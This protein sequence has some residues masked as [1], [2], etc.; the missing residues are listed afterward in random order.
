MITN[1]HRINIFWKKL[2]NSRTH[3]SFFLKFPPMTMTWD[4]SC[5]C[6]YG[7]GYR[8]TKN[9]AYKQVI[10]DT[11]DSLSACLIR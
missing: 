4:S 6:S 10:L 8:L 7:N 9:P 11:A 1:I 5:F 2:R 3:W